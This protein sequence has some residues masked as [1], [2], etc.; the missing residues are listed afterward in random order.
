MRFKREGES[1]GSGRC[2]IRD[3]KGLLQNETKK[4]RIMAFV[5]LS[6]LSVTMTFTQFGFI[7]VGAV[8]HN[9][10]YVLG[11]LGPVS[12]T[13]FLLGKGAGTLQG[14]LSGAVL[15]VHSHL[16]PLDVFERYFVS[17]SN[18]VVLYS[19][20]G[21]L[22][23][24]SFAVAL[25]NRPKG[26]RRALYLGLVSLL[27]SMVV[28]ITFL[29]NAFVKMVNYL[30]DAYEQTQGMTTVPLEGYGALETLGRIDEQVLLDALL[31]F[32]AV[33][34]V[35]Y[36][37]HRRWK[38]AGN[39]SVRTTFRVQ[40]LMVLA[41]VFCVTQ[42]AVFTAV[43]FREEGTAFN[44]MGDELSYISDHLAK[45]TAHHEQLLDA[46]N[47][48]D[49]SDEIRDAILETS[50]IDEVLEGYD[51][52]DGTVLVFEEGVVTYSYNPAYPVGKRYEEL[53]DVV[54]TGSLEELAEQTWP[55]MTVYS[56]KPFSDLVD[57]ETDETVF[58]YVE[59]GYNRVLES[60][61]IYLLMMM[62]SSMVFAN[63]QGVVG[64]AF[65]VALLLLATVY[66]LAAQLLRKEVVGPINRTNASL[67]RITEGHLDETVSEVRSLEF[68]SLSAG[69]NVT[70]DSLKE[71]IAAEAAR[72]DS[73]LAT[74]K[75]IQESALPRVFPPFPEISAF[76]IYASM[77]AAKEVGGDFFDFFLIDD[78]TL[79]FLIADVSG[80]GIPASLFMMAA[81]AELSN[82]MSSGM[83]LSD[84]V[85][86]ANWHLCQGN[87]ADMFV[88][89]WAATLDYKTGLLTYVNAGHNPPLLRHEG[90]WVWL[91]DRG[92][93]FLG[94]F[95]MA[96]YQ[97]NKL[98]LS[99]GDELFLYTD[100]VSEAFSADLRQYGDE[101]IERFLVSRGALHPRPLIES[102]RA[103][104]ARWASGTEQSDDITM[105]ALEY[106]VSPQATGTLTI[107]ATLDQL[108]VV[109][110]F[111]HDALRDRSCPLSTQ[112]QIDVA[113]EELFVNVCNYAY[114]DAGEPGTATIEYIYNANPNS[115]TVAI[116][117][118]G[119][120]FDPLDHADPLTPK[121]IDEA[122]I[123][124]LGILMVKR[125]TD[126]LSYVRDGN[127]NVVA[128]VKS[129]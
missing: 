14:V 128:F 123:G 113:L 69:I 47:T 57:P 60:N 125:M 95:E 120:P 121:S 82:Y 92:G 124:G 50:S 66:V 91:R 49:L 8:S 102:M 29:F 74:A 32:L 33:L 6:I 18:S 110:D 5:A 7:G 107:P 16:Q 99:V 45:Q 114:R 36:F 105:L 97:S 43:T 83:G 26:L 61:G 108:D 65:L 9:I 68:A 106:G 75:A 84:A 28:S 4:T 53:F 90:K 37:V 88:T 20:A 25:H 27:V 3:W 127:Q 122:K 86:T 87:D 117:D 13:A 44:H 101:R 39:V 77:D 94:T 42:T 98:Q 19:M 79:G 64:W 22:L 103:D 38:E 111:I 78:H 129:W 80:K 71:A 11:L 72:I 100:G 118:Y 56:T 15:Y 119:V 67:A 30:A 41:L 54:R 109:F 35:D 63:R 55:R 85:Q 48:Y 2:R 126:D 40:L 46:V 10:G 59:L 81:K 70:V 73:D 89:V 76:D 116:S 24:L 104:L 112:N 96:R 58:S 21:F 34:A 17:V 12:V 31:M 93:L 23:G 51:L 1:R 62:P 115:L 52:S